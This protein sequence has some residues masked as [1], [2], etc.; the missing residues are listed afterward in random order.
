MK[1]LENYTLAELKG[2][3][4]EI[5]SIKGLVELP[6]VKT[7]EEFIDVLYSD[8]DYSV[9]LLQENRHLIQNDSEDR[10]TVQIITNLKMKGYNAEHDVQIGG[11]VDLTVRHKS[12]SW[13]GEAKI[14]SSYEYLFEGFQQLTTRYSVGTLDANHGGILIYIKGANAKQVMKRWKEKLKNEKISGMTFDTCAKNNLAFLSKHP[15]NVSGNDYH[16][17][18]IPACLYFAPQDKSARSSQK[19]STQQ[20]Q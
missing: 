13:L 15:H 19:G 7:Y 5:P 10:I 3:S 8:I 9:Q 17:R 18:H 2:L 11:H 14:H 20:T 16:I 4:S 6:L 1:S 12:Y